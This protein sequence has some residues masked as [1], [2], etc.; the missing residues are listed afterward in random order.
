MGKPSMLISGVKWSSDA[1]AKT[2][3]PVTG[4][5]IKK[6]LNPTVEV[7]AAEVARQQERGVP[8]QIYSSL[9]GKTF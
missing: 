7:A 3:N 2:Y 8:V 1:A 5:L 6:V 9:Q 4:K